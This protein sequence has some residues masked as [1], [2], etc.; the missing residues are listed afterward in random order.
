MSQDLT[1]RVALRLWHREA[2]SLEHG[3]GELRLLI[4]VQRSLGYMGLKKALIAKLELDGYICEDDIDNAINE[5][6]EE[7]GEP[8][9]RMVP[10]PDR[11]LQIDVA[12]DKG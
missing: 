4:D 6:L 11:Q 1:E 5:L 2:I 12:E 3:V 8:M 7:D 9:V 10:F